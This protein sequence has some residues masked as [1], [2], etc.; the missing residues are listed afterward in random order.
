MRERVQLNFAQRWRVRLKAPQRAARNKRVRIAL[1]VLA[2]LVCIV[3][4]SLP[5]VYEYELNTELAVL[6]QRIAALQEIDGKVYQVQALEEQL[7]LQ[8]KVLDFVGGQR[9]NPGE[10]LDRL[11]ESLPAGAIL[12]NVTLNQDNTLRASISFL[13]PVDAANFWSAMNV[14]Q[15][16]E[17]QD[18]GALSLKDERQT[19]VM[20]FKLR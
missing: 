3:L 13:S 17:T 5:W 15:Y 19:I 10:V 11:K 14:S 1:G 4:G 20:D 12:E 9:K 16:F 6:N 2:G 18:I 8:E 7:G